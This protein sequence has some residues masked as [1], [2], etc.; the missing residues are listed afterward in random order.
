[1]ADWTIRLLDSPAEMTA[2]EA[3]QRSVWTDS[4]TDVIPAH[5]L[6]AVVH[7]GGLGI[8]AFIGDELVGF[9]FGFPGL[10]HASGGPQLKHHSH[11]LGV[12]PDM[13]GKGIGFALKRAQWQMVR[14]QG[15]ERVTWT[16]DPLLSRNAHLNVARLGAVCNTYLR[17][18]YGE[19]R[20]GLNAG[21]PS[22]RFMVDW[23]LNTRRVERRL[24]HR[25]RKPL[26]SEHY[27]TAEATRLD[28]V[29][30]GVMTPRPPAELPALT[31]SL[32]MVEIPA[33]F[34]KLKA[35]D[36]GLARDWRFYCREA[37][38]K[39]FAGGYLVTDFIEADGHHFYIL[40]HGEATL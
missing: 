9:A 3:L 1:M 6:L 30:D 31:G 27:F 23:W 18:E 21:L 26:S 2:A 17:A 11:I 7:N 15:I 16:Y 38:E 14:K 4:E 19:M 25:P 32:L 22:D 33:D 37:F 34:I 24:S 39:A 20:D 36:L 28:A 35:V 10:T 5:L 8:G 13:R 29:V 40:T 12:R